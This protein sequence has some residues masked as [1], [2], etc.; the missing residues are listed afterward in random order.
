M[1]LF[2]NKFKTE[3]IAQPYP[4]FDGR[5]N[6]ERRQPARQEQLGAVKCLAQGYIDTQLGGAGDPTSNLS[7]TR[8]VLYVLS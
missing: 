1:Y 2:P 4:S 6:H 3:F 7:V 8:Q 5:V